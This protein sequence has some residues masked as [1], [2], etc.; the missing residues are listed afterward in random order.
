MFMNHDQ[1]VD[2]T[3]RFFQTGKLRET[4][5]PHPIPRPEKKSDPKTTSKKDI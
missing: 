3:A 5:D 2:C 4:G 1:A